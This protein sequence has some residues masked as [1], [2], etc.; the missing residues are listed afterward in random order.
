ME[1]NT[2]IR[3]YA[4][5]MIVGSIYRKGGATWGCGRGFWG[6]EAWGVGGGGRGMKFITR[7][8]SSPSNRLTWSRQGGSY[9]G[10]Y[11]LEEFVDRR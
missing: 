3:P 11:L 1:K 2:I 7:R 5:E 9:G 10:S 6:R 4:M 8:K